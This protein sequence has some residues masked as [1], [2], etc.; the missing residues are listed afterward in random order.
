MSMHNSQYFKCIARVRKYISV[1][2]MYVVCQKCSFLE[3]SVVAFTK[4]YGYV[5]LWVVQLLI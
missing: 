1:L 2:A 4:C 3:L 5:S